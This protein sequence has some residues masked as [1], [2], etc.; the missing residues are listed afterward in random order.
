MRP[1]EVGNLNFRHLRLCSQQGQVDKFIIRR[2][3][4]D[5]VNFQEYKR[6]FETDSFVTVDEWMILG[7]SEGV[8]GG[9][10]EDIRTAVGSQVD[11]AGQRGIEQALVAEALRA[12]MQY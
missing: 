4:R 8:G 11:R 9:A 7:E 6:G 2:T 3:Q 12:A 10:V 5:S 1:E